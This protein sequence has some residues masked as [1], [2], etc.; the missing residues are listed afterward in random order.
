VAAWSGA[1]TLIA[2]L[3]SH[4]LRHPDFEPSTAAW[5][6]VHAT[7]VRRSKGASAAQTTLRLVGHRGGTGRMPV[8][9]ETPLQ[10]SRLAAAAELLDAFD[11]LCAGRPGPGPADLLHCSERLGAL[12]AEARPGQ[13]ALGPWFR[14]PRDARL[15]LRVLESQQPP[16][17]ETL[18]LWRAAAATPGHVSGRR[19]SLPPPVASLP[20]A[21]AVPR[22]VVK[23]KKEQPKAPAA[24]EP[25]PASTT[26]PGIKQRCRLCGRPGHNART[27]PERRDA[28]APAPLPQPVTLSAG[29]A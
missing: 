9:P 20:G 10:A 11:A 23:G 13:Q 24:P 18:E 27:C 4:F 2:A 19:S 5:L 29:S 14:V 8:A 15:M 1:A 16:A 6:G 22:V 25:S 28:P 7:L 21:L 26:S 3:Q 12:G 17:S